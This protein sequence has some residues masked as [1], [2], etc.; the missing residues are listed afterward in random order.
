MDRL[1]LD[2]KSARQLREA[3]GDDSGAACETV[4][5]IVGDRGKMNNPVTNSGGVLLGTVLAIGRAHPQA[6]VLRKGDRVV[7]LPSSTCIPLHLDSVLSFEGEVV[8]VS[9]TAVLFSSMTA[10]LVP[11]D[12]PPAV[13]LSALDVSSIVPQVEQALAEV[14]P[15]AD[16]GRSAATVYIHG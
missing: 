8:S 11:K 15:A 10:A 6:G 3:H 12:L 4:A 2:S 16:G 14:R 7:P 5:Q 9:G 13:A 1:L